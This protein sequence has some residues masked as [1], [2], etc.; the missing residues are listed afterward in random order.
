MARSERAARA[1]RSRR[2]RTAADGHADA[3][4]GHAHSFAERACVFLSFALLLLGAVAVVPPLR[5]E[6]AAT[7]APAL[8]AEGKAPAAPKKK[9]HGIFIS[10]GDDAPG[11][12]ELKSKLTP[13]QLY[14]IELARAKNPK[15]SDM[16]DIA[17]PVTF[18]AMVLGIVGVVVWGRLR[19]NRMMHETMRVFA[20]KG[21]PVPPELFQGAAFAGAAGQ[22]SA[23]SPRQKSDL[24]RGIFWVATGLG[25]IGFFIADHDRAWGLGCVPLFIGFGYLVAWK[26]ETPPKSGPTA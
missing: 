22:V 10:I 4:L 21:Q 7:P 20:E 5:A 14:E 3:R 15:G 1:P 13:Q 8:E 19:R 2:G 6:P 12:D 11:S 25:V 9:D 17:V 23:A 24:R 18:F 26:L 16:E